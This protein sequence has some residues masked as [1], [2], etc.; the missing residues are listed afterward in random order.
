MF[1]EFFGPQSFGGMHRASDPKELM[2]FDV[3]TDVGIVGPE[4]FVRDFA[5]LKIA[6]VV[7]RGRLTGKF[8]DD[9]RQGKY[10]VA[11]GVVCKGGSGAGLWMAKIKTNAYLERLRQAF[12]ER[13]EDYWE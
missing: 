12:K 2:L 13:W 3:Q 9:V 5:E 10:G 4:Q 8:A 11:E 7:Y 6:R 1:T